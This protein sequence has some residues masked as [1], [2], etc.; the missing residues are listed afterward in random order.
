MNYNYSLAASFQSAKRSS[1]MSDATSVSSPSSDA[2]RSA[3]RSPIDLDDV[4][5]EF[6]RYQR[7][8]SSASF[9][10]EW[11]EKEVGLREMLDSARTDPGVHSSSTPRLSQMDLPRTSESIIRDYEQRMER[12]KSV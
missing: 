9:E 5:K 2:Y 4:T 7:M 3:R 12:R 1:C 6:Q 10:K 11:S 8:L